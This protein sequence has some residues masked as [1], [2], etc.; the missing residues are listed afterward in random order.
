[1]FEEAAECVD[2]LEYLRDAAIRHD[3]ALVQEARELASIFAKAVQTARTN[4]NRL[5]PPKQLVVL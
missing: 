1:M 5:K 3:P 2:V 4:T